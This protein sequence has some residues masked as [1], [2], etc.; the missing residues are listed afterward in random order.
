V[1]GRFL[2]GILSDLH[3]WHLDE[4]LYIQDNR[5]KIGGKTIYHPGFQRVWTNNYPVSG[6][7]VLKW[8]AF[9]QI[10]RKWHRKLSKVRLFVTLATRFVIHMYQCFIECVQT[11]EFMHVYNAIIVLKEMLPVFP[12][13][14][15]TDTGGALDTAMDKLLE[16]EERGDLKILGR[17]YVKSIC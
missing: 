13:A 12:L 11:G 10:L 8:V 4:Q 2:L 14:S 5:T 16:T 3:K 15:V 1:S 17:A 6:D 9:Q 7:N